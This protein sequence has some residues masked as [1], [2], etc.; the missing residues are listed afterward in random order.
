MVNRKEIKNPTE[1]ARIRID[2]LQ[3]MILRHRDDLD[4]RRNCTRMMQLLSQRVNITL[5]QYLK[6][7]FCRKCGTPYGKET[8]I[9]VRRKIVHVRCGYCGEI[10]RLP[11]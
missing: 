3:G 11:Y 9:R 7:S 1:I 2:S 8:L 6:R 10:R 4:F 5:P